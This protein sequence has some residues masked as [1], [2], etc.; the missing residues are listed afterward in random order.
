MPQCR[1]RARPDVVRNAWVVGRDA[2]SAGQA[3]DVEA[4]RFFDGRHKVWVDDIVPGDVLIE[5]KDG[6]LYRVKAWAFDERYEWV[7]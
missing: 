2:V 4:A 3:K 1:R 6:A 7:P 5:E